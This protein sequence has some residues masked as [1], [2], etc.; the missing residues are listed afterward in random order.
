MKPKI[1]PADPRK[2]AQ[3]RLEETP[4]DTLGSGWAALTRSSHSPAIAPYI[5][6][7]LWVE[8][9]RFHNILRY[10]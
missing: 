6:L 1:M 2:V 5:Q 8:G 4:P 3:E 10:R 7:H 9:K